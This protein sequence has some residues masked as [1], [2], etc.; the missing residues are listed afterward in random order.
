MFSAR[1]RWDLRTNRLETIRAEKRSRG[2]AVL[3]LTEANPTS[4]GLHYPPDLLA[5]LADAGGLVYE[6]L[7]FGWPDARAAVA[8]DYRR[9]GSPLDPSRIVLTASTSEAYAFLFKLL[10]DAGDEVLVPRPGYPLFEYL[11]GLEG[12]RPVAYP[13][14]YDGE[15]HVDLPALRDRAGARTRMVVVVTPHNPTGAFLKRDELE[16][17]EAF[18]GERSLALVADEVFADYPLRPDP[19]R[20]GSVARDGPALSL[21][22]GGL[23]KSCGLPQ[24]KLSWIAIAGP[25][26][27]RTEAQAR[28]EIVA[29]TYL[30]VS[31]PVQRALPALLARRGE[32][33]RPI[34]ER[35]ASNLESLRR[36]TSSPGCPATLLE[37]EGGW[38]AVLRVPATVPEAERVEALLEER[39][40][41]VHPGYFFDFPREAYLVLSLLPRAGVF[42]AAVERILETL[43]L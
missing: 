12:V 29:D 1:T 26:A 28:L 19:R 41:L 42:D 35:V 14:E 31:T 9:R 11:A 18:C 37:P 27:L 10:C 23:S 4:V 33:Q 40:V 5:P 8:D 6:P 20:A 36:R 2:E 43:V 25:E 7:A 15:W 22:L 24:L 13:L 21:A 38:Y 3:D 16:A 34:A 17:L 32:R 30:S 39:N